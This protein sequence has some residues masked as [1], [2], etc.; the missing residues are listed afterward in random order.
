VI[1]LPDTRSFFHRFDS[2]ERPHL[3]ARAFCRNQF[4][5]NAFFLL[6][7][8]R[9]GL[10]RAPLTPAGV[11]APDRRLV[12]EYRLHIQILYDRLLSD[13]VPGQRPHGLEC[14]RG[15]AAEKRPPRQTLPVA[16]REAG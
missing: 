7:G 6:G 13:R 1:A 4:F 12:H 3:N 16:A 15:R 11:V 14:Q 9:L 2:L 5:R 8:I 10:N